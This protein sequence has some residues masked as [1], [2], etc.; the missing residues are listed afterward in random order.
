LFNEIDKKTCYLLRKN[1]DNT[2]DLNEKK[3]DS[4]S[5]FSYH[6]FL[7]QKVEEAIISESLEKY[8]FM[9]LR[10]LYEKTAN[11]L[12]YKHWTDIIPK[13]YDEEQRKLAIRLLN[14]YSHSTLS[15]ET[16]SDL[17]TKEIEKAEELFANINKLY[18]LFG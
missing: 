16:I 9:F 11:F 6:L 2:Y 4:N 12:G 18:T 15:N 3:G 7:K 8:H 1:E 13:N 14:L 5:S 10:N 17:D